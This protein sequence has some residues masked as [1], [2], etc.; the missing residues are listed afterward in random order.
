[1]IHLLSGVG[2]TRLTAACK[3]L[4][5]PEGLPLCKQKAAGSRGQGMGFFLVQRPEQKQ[6]P[7]VVMQSAPVASDLGQLEI[8]DTMG[9]DA[10]T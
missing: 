4:N 10:L 5:N 9:T 3:L 7:R 6:K 8:E 2:A 1:L